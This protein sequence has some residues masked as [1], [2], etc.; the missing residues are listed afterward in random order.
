M[1]APEGPHI[2][3][4][5]RPDGTMI[6]EPTGYGGDLCHKAAEPYWARHGGPDEVTPTAEA[7]DPTCLEREARQ[8]TPRER[9]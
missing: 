8:E 9:A 6:K 2:R 7:D 5:Y 4:V 3:T 1:P